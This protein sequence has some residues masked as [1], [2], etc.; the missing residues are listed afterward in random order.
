MLG[1]CITKMFNVRAHFRKRWRF[2]IA[3]THNNVIVVSR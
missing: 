2:R 3:R 1:S